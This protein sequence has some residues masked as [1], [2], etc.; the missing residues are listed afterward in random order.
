MTK[1]TVHLQKVSKD[2]QQK[3]VEIATYENQ[4]DFYP[5]IESSL[6]LAARYKNAHPFAVFLGEEICGFLLIG[7]DEITKLW[8]IYRL[9]IDKNYQ[10][11]GIGRAAME[12]ALSELKD[13]HGA[14]EVL[15]VYQEENIIAANL[16]CTLGFIR[17]GKE[18]NKILAK[19][20]L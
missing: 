4:T 2:N 11:Q 17:Y 1:L 20:M 6:E 10:R 7:I 9:V 3:I 8:K 14:G 15:I 5:S 12:L 19:V 13:N 16:Y 18:G